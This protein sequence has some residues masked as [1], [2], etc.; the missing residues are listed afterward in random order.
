MSDAC[1]DYTKVKVIDDDTFP[2]STY[3]KEIR[4]QAYDEI[5]GAGL[6]TEYIKFNFTD[7]D[8]FLLLAIKYQ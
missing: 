5:K 4:S 8:V 3:A 2:T 1:L 6:V 7:L